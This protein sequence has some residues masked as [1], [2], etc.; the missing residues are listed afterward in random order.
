[1]IDTNVLGNG[2]FNSVLEVSKKNY[3]KRI[4]NVNISL[5]GEK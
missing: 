5:Y 4:L 3:L 2:K 1:M